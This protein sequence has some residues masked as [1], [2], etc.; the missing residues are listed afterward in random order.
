MSALFYHV[1]SLHKSHPLTVWVRCSLWR[2]MP[3]VHVMSNT[4]MFTQLKFINMPKSGPL[5]F[6][7]LIHTATQ[8]KWSINNYV[9]SYFIQKLAGI[10]LAKKC[11]FR[12]CYVSRYL[13]QLVPLQQTPAMNLNDCIHPLFVLRNLISEHYLYTC[14]VAM[15]GVL[16]FYSNPFKQSRNKL[17]L[18]C[19]CTLK[20]YKIRDNV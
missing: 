8:V 14:F 11:V 12:K 13:S 2:N 5:Q 4:L 15:T 19:F 20:K 17:G 1:T 16:R 10:K 9:L 18:E 6:A 7:I 3:Q